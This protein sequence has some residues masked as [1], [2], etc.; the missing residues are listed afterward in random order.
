MPRNGEVVMEN[1]RRY[2]AIASLYRRTAAFRPLQS[3]SLLRQADEWEHLAIAELE[4]Y[5][6]LHD[7]AVCDMQPKIDRRRDARWEMVAA[8]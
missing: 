1:V 7:G 6:T 5:F 8:A 2:R 3:A 4:A